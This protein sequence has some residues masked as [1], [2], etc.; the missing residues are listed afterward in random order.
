MKKSILP[1]E[2]DIKILEYHHHLQ[3]RPYRKNIN[4]AQNID[5][6]KKKKKF[7]KSVNYR[8]NLR[9]ME[10][11]ES[12]ADGVIKPRPYFFLLKQY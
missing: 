2:L 3:S 4:I 10:L 11:L 12:K 5:T 9:Y 6:F 8:A 7:K 1:E